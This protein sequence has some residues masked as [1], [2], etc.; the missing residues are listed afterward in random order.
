MVAGD[1]MDLMA[2]LPVENGLWADTAT[3][4]Q[5]SDAQAVFDRVPPLYFITRPRGGRKSADAAGMAVALH[6]TRAPSGATS[7]C[8]AAEQRS[9]RAHHRQRSLV[10][11]RCAR[12]PEGDESGATSC[13]VRGRPGDH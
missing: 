13:S 1:P 9:G 8:V 2:A 10:P 3:S 11:R 5:R 7:Y 12:S 6:L 4:W